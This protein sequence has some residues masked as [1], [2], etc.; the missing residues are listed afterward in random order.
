MK[1][2]KNVPNQL[3]R[4]MKSEPLF[5]PCDEVLELVG[6]FIHSFALPACYLQFKSHWK[7]ESY[8]NGCVI[9]GPTLHNYSI[10]IVCLLLYYDFSV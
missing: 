1:L 4:S 7:T 6:S 9:Q 8:S 5:V 2:S 10:D 3:S